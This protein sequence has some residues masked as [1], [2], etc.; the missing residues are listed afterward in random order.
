[1]EKL[2][3][4]QE[5]IL[6]HRLGITFRGQVWVWLLPP[7]TP[8]AVYVYVCS[9]YVLGKE[10]TRQG[11]MNLFLVPYSVEQFNPPSIPHLFQQR[12]LSHYIGATIAKSSNVVYF[13]SLRNILNIF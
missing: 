11:K 8:P 6:F 2:E 5:A 3:R 4:I 9:P 1:M 7:E 13:A 10:T 12:G